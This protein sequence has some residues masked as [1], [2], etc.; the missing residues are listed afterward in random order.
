LA[1]SL[2]MKPSQEV[3]RPIVKQ[4]EHFLGGKGMFA[5]LGNEQSVLIG[6][7]FDFDFASVIIEVSNLK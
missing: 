5:P 2:G 4:K 3:M 1:Q 6:L 7:N